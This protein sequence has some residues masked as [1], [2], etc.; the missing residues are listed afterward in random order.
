M[1]VFLVIRYFSIEKYQIQAILEPKTCTPMERRLI[2]H[3]EFQNHKFTRETLGQTEYRECQFLNCSLPEADLSQSIFTDCHFEDCDLSVA[4]LKNTCFQ[5]VVFRNCKMM[6]LRFE[7]ADPFALDFQLEG[8]QL[9]Y[10]SFYQVRRHQ[11]H[12]RSCKLSEADFS[13][14]DLEGAVFEDCEL[15]GARFEDT[16]LAGADLRSAR[17]YQIDPGKNV[18]RGARFSWPGLLGLLRQYEIEVEF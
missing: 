1:A 17:N 4:T 16:I 12:F 18:I 8:C 2:E 11:L 9:P 13:G 6:G 7:Q 5:R 15:E 14:A 3:E 10:A